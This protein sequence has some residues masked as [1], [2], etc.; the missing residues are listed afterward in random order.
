MT[1]LYPDIDQYMSG[2]LAE[3]NNVEQQ[4]EQE[5]ETAQQKNLEP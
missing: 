3:H 2:D 1:G 5:L 4:P